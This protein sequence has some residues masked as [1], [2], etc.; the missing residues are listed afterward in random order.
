[1]KSNFRQSMNWLHTWSGFIFGWLLYF[2]FIT[3]TVGYFENE[4]DRWMK[5]EVSV[6]DNAID[7]DTVLVA[8]EQQLQKLAPD[9]PSWYISF[10]FSRIPYIQIQWLQLANKEANIPKKWHEKN[11]DMETR[12]VNNVR[13]T[14]GGETLYRLHYNLHYMP[15]FHRLSHWCR[16]S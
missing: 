6:V 5:P 11:I 16:H 14:A 7:Q 13:E 12:E 1:M 9:S 10:P 4:I 2:I 8:A 3:G 15:Q